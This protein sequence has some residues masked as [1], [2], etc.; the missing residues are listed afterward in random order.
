M[1][2]QHGPVQ[3]RL[4]RFVDPIDSRYANLNNFQLGPKTFARTT[5]KT[6]LIHPDSQPRTVP[7]F[8]PDV[9]PWGHFLGRCSELRRLA[10]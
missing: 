3:Y 1:A 10:S 6:K 2:G 5:R 8:K 7:V 9:P 4:C